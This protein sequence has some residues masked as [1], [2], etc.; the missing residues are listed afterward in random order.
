VAGN[1]GDAGYDGPC[2]PKGTGVHRYRFTIW[3]MLAT[4]TAIAP[5]AKAIDVNAILSRSAIDHAS[6]TGTVTP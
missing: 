5:D 6:V 2:P 4:A 3:A 1:F